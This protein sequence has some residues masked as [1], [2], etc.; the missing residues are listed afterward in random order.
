MVSSLVV[1]P[2]RPDGDSMHGLIMVDHLEPRLYHIMGTGWVYHGVIMVSADD[3]S[4]SACSSHYSCKNKSKD[5]T[6]RSA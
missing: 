5:G 3:A 6:G 4:T 1:F 2:K